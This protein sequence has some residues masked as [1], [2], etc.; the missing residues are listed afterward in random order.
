MMRVLAAFILIIGILLTGFVVVSE[1]DGGPLPLQFGLDLAGGTHLLYRADTSEVAPEER[2]ESLAALRDVIERRTNLFGVAE[3]LVQIEQSSF[4]AEVR[5]DRLIVELPGVTDID[6]A[7][8]IIGE[9]PLLE[10]RIQDPNASETATP[11]EQFVSVGLTGRFITDAELAFASGQQ[12]FSNEPLVL[13]NFNQEGAELFETV[14]RENVGRQLAIFLDGE[15]ISAPV[16][17]EA[18]SG[19]TAQISGGFTPEEARDLARDLNFG[20]LPVPIELIST[21]SIGPSLGKVILE[22]G[23][24]AGAIGLILIMVFMVLWYRLPGFIASIALIFYTALL[25]L[26]MKLIPITL[27][28]AGIAG[29]ILSLGMAVDANVLIFERMKEELLN[30]KNIKDAIKDGFSRAWLPIRDGNIS[31]LLAAVILFWLGTSI[32]EGFALV[33]AL[34]VLLSMFSAITVTR[35]LLLAIAPKEDG[36]VSRALFGNGIKF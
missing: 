36:K 27:T 31:S 13:V 14:T 21:Q 4:V 11:F 18:I 35:I 17:R 8:R 23:V 22:D 25:L 19:G 20:A 6:E 9:T 3:P 26:V 34:G 32:V 30:G 1:R 28:A 7:I 16:I 24:R 2:E 10:F 5:E 33:F 15:V 29:I 12:G